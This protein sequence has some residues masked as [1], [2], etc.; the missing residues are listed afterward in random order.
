MKK[1]KRIYVEIT[2]KCNLSCDFCPG[3]GRREGF[4]DR[5]LFGRILS[6]VGEFTGQLYFHVLGEP[7]LHPEL[8]SFLDMCHEQG[9][10]VN[11]TT[12]G[13]LIDRRADILLSKPAL[14]QVNFSLH[15]FESNYRDYP[16]DKYLDSIFGFIES[17]RKCEKLLIGLRLWNITGTG[18]NSLNRHILD[19][20]GKK[21]KEW[22]TEDSQNHPLVLSLDSIPEEVTPVNGLKLF[23]NVFLHIAEVFDWPD[24]KIEDISS[25]GFCYGLRD[26]AAILVDGTV[27]P[28][29]LDGKGTISLGNIKNESFADIIG[30]ERALK[31][32]EGFSRREAVEA[33]CRKCGYRMRFGKN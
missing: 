22:N 4:M 26:Q 30:S 13:S 33:L 8:G 24:P 12:N 29:C 19:R 27:V 9:I 7:L 10:K 21:A 28:C 2:N 23:N 3:P 11:I 25:R 14:R 18:T 20:I 6:E 1:L 32:Y 5:E 31:L 15:S 16:I 17:T